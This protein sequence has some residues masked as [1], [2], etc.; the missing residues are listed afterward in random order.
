MPECVIPLPN[1]PLPRPPIEMGIGF[2]RP[3]RLKRNL[4]Y[5]IRLS[6]RGS[7]TFSNVLAS[8]FFNLSRQRRHLL[9]TQSRNAPVYYNPSLQRLAKRLR[10]E[11]QPPV[12]PS[13]RERHRLLQGLN[14][15]NRPSRGRHQQRP[16]PNLPERTHR[17]RS[18]F[19]SLLKI[20]AV[21]LAINHLEIV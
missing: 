2:Y 6:V 10:R 20:F 17:Q 8:A 16:P 5:N 18:F 12:P 11:L 9:R 3:Y 7:S 21:F 13:L 15:R 4:F 1:M 14:P 19:K